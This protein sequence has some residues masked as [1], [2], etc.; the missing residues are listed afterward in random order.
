MTSIQSVRE[1][2]QQHVCWCDTQWTG[3]V[4]LHAVSGNCSGHHEREEYD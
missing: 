3:F 4:T 2:L 1:G